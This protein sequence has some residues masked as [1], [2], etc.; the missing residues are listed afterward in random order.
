MAK[1][2]EERFWTKIEKRDGSECWI[3][4]G[5]VKSDGYGNFCSGI[6]QFVGAHKMS[7][8]IKHGKKVPDGMCVCHHCDTPLC[9]NPA[10]L[11]LGTAKEN[12]ADA[13]KKG[14]LK[15]RETPKGSQHGRAKITEIVVQA[16][17]KDFSEQNLPRKNLAEKYQIPYGTV[18]HI[19]AGRTWRHI[20]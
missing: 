6:K 20:Q 5:A 15:G 7:W 18:A 16:I 8:E 12:A 9:V 3:W 19:L 17:R 13:S 1:T 2:I 11:F 10:H 4:K 14:R